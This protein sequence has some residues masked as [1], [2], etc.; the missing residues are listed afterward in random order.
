MNFLCICRL[1]VIFQGIVAGVDVGQVVVD[2]HVVLIMDEVMGMVDG[3]MGM[4][5]GAVVRPCR[6][7]PITEGRFAVPMWL[8]NY[9]QLKVL[10]LEG[11]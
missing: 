10:P 2:V 3:V 7:I 4:V 11:R 8:Q 6:T 9:V 1:L 5:E